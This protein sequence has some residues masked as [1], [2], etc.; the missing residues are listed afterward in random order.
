MA[1]RNGVQGFNSGGDAILAHGIKTSLAGLQRI[2]AAL[3]A[4]L[5]AAPER[6][7]DFKFEIQLAI[8]ED[9]RWDSDTAN[10]QDGSS[11]AAIGALALGLHHLSH[12]TLVL[13]VGTTGSCHN[14]W[15]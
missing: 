7:K 9:C 2:V 12:P 13:C 1:A 6:R 10:V 11:P 3:S 5:D 8:A 15:P 4:Q 14:A